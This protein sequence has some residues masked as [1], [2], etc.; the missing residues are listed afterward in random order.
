ME[1]LGDFFEPFMGK[2][3]ENEITKQTVGE[4]GLHV[5]CLN[6]KG[7]MKM[8][9]FD[10]DADDYPLVI[11]IL[12]S[13]AKDRQAVLNYLQR[14]DIKS[15]LAQHDRESILAEAVISNL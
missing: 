10:S 7:Q 8:Y 13:L 6:C 2:R 4:T 12:V 14:D 9:M 11:T 5:L 1:G 15:W 3:K